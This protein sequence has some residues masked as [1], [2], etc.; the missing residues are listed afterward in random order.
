MNS[1][2][3]R[4]KAELFRR[5]YGTDLAP[6]WQLSVNSLREQKYSYLLYLLLQAD[7]RPAASNF[8]DLKFTAI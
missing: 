3:R 6:V 1:F 2:S 5:A 4:L 7:Q 8:C